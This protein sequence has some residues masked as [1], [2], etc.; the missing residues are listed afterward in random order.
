[1][2][3]NNGH[4]QQRWLIVNT[5]SQLKLKDENVT[6][7]QVWN[8]LRFHGHAKMALKLV[9]RTLKRFESTGGVKDKPKIRKK[10]KIVSCVRA[11]VIKHAKKSKKT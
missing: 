11:S 10:R 8:Y 3:F 5:H 9:Q 4:E 1:M 6:P 7:T 2:S